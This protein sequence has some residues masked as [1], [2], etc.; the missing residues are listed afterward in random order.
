MCVCA[1]SVVSDSLRPHGLQPARLL[2]P[3]NFPGNNTGVACHFT[4]QGIFQTQGL[5]SYLW[6][7]LHWRVDSVPLLI[8]QPGIESVP[9]AVEA[10]SLNHWT[11]KAGPCI[12]L[13]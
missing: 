5:N 4:P 6:H 9:P 11:A 2:C 8:P 1:H 12:S 10:C 7:L 13:L 3:W